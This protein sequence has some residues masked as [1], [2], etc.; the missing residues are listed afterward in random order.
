MAT[1]N[2]TIVTKAEEIRKALKANPGKGPAEI[3]RMLTEQHG[4]AF[5]PK[6]VSTIKTKM[7][8][9]SGQKTAVSAAARKTAAPRPKAAASTPA[10]GVAAMVSNLQDYIRRLGKEE[11]RH[12]INTL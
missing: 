6:M 2:S 9:R 11:L 1:K 12:L 7:K 4:V 8:R 10:R 5:R 3:A